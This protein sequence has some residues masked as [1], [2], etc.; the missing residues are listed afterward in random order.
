MTCRH[1]AAGPA[2]AA[3]PGAVTTVT[4]AVAFGLLALD[5]G[6]F[7]VVFPVGFGGVLPLSL[8]AARGRSG[9]DGDASPPSDDES[10]TDVERRLRTL[11]GRYVQGELGEEAF[12]REVER[13]L[14]SADAERGRGDQGSVGGVEAA[15]PD[16][17][18]IDE[19]P[20]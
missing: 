4:L 16:R 3:V 18:S 12:E 20:A 8:A 11:R 19:D 9:R 17:A 5:V 2:V 15:G 6:W 1:P 13:L 10:G 7:W 14:R